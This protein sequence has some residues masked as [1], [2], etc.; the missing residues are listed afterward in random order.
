MVL[1]RGVAANRRIRF[2]VAKHNT[3]MLKLA[4]LLGAKPVANAEGDELWELNAAA[5]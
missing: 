3:R 2:Y 4:H 5:L 1:L